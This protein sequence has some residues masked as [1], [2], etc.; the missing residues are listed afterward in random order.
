MP[1]LRRIVAATAMA[2]AVSASILLS[3]PAFAGETKTFW[4]TG[5]STSHSTALFLAQHNAVSLASADGFNTATQCGHG[6]YVTTQLMP[7][8]YRVQ[9]PL[10][11]TR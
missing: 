1:A 9:S 6:Q 4:G 8:F 7:G 10:I 3:G 11:C 5:M 2:G